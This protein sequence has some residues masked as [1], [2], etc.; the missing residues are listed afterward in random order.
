VAA[1]GPVTAAA[2]EAAGMR[3]DATAS[4]HTIPGLVA[5]IERA[6]AA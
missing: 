1:I 3:V 5:A 4:E 6:T 2:A